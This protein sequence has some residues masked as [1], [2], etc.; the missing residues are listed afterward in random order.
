MGTGTFGMFCF[1]WT[2]ECSFRLRSAIP[3]VLP[4]PVKFALWRRSEP[5]SSEAIVV[6]VMVAI[7]FGKVADHVNLELSRYKVRPY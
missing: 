6:I 3:S 4:L 1:T 5:P 2:R 7:V